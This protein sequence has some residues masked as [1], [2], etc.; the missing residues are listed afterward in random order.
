MCEISEKW[1]REGE[2][3]GEARGE[4]RGEEKTLVTLVCQK[5]KLGQRLEKIASDLVKEVSVIEPIYQAAEKFAP[6]YDPSF[7]LESLRGK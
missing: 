3:A 7:V 4:A 2:A 5:M 1:F 6:G